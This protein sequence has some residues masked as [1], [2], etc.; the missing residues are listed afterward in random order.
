MHEVSKLFVKLEV[1]IKENE[2]LNE[3]CDELISKINA[4]STVQELNNSDYVLINERNDNESIF[5]VRKSNHECSSNNESENYFDQIFSQIQRNQK[6]NNESIPNL[7]L[8]LLFQG[9]TNEF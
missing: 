7:E 6:D 4:E 9:K 3:I 8:K 2:R 1:L 5:N